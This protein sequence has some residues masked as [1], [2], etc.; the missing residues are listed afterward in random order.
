MILAKF[1]TEKQLRITTYFEQTNVHKTMIE[2]M[3]NQIEHMMIETDH[4]QY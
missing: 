4:R 2:K 3:E 1:M